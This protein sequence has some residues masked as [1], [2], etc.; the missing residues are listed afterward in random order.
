MNVIL[1]DKHRVFTDTLKVVLLQQPEFVT[2]NTFGTTEEFLLGSDALPSPDLII[3]E[4]P[5]RSERI[6]NLIE[7]YVKGLTLI[8]KLLVL[9]GISDNHSIKI[10]FRN[11]VNGFASK[12]ATLEELL[13]AIRTVMRGETFVSPALGMNLM[14]SLL[15]EDKISYNFSAREREVLQNVCKGYTI[16]ETAHRLN[17]SAHTVQSYHRNI[18]KKLKMRR[19]ADLIVFAVRNGLYVPDEDN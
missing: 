17:L 1:I 9:S 10:A 15:A 18:M 5:N 11:G 12:G 8:P 6:Y 7:S 3:L 19:T 4:V 13:I 16:K 2:V 14:Q